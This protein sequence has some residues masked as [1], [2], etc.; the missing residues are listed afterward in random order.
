M[1]CVYVRC[2]C[3]SLTSQ[4]SFSFKYTENKFESVNFSYTEYLSSISTAAAAAAAAATCCS[5]NISIH[6]LPIWRSKVWPMG[7]F[8]RLNVCAQLATA[9]LMLS[10]KREENMS[11]RF[12]ISS[13]SSL[14]LSLLAPPCPFL[15]PAMGR[16]RKFIPWCR[17][18]RAFVYAHARV[19]RPFEF[20]RTRWY[21][22]VFFLSSSARCQKFEKFSF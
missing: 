1:F 17:I 2:I 18:F 20:H 6:H 21:S 4:T 15:S 12:F 3:V 16:E 8:A 10:K 5:P 13:H 14:S 11:N 9:L 22:K 19:A 7:L